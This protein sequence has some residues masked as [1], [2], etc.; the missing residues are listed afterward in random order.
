MQAPLR[1][2]ARALLLS[3]VILLGACAK[4]QPSLVSDPDAKK[5]GALPW[6]QQEQWETAGQFKEGQGT[7]HR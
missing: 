5:D 7:D 3:G 6:N 2:V 4:E 1:K